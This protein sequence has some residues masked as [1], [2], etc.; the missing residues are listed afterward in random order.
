[1]SAETIGSGGEDGDAIRIG[2]YALGLLPA[3]E[4]AALAR[5][6][7]EEP[8]LAAELRFWQ[9]RLSDLDEEFA[10]VSPPAAVLPAIEKRLFGSAE[11]RGGLWESLGFWRGLAAAGVAVAVLSL[12]AHM[13]RPVPVDP[14]AFAVQLVAA[15]NAQEGSGVQ[16]VALFDA[17]TGNVRITSLSGEPVPDR[18]FELWYIEAG[19]DPVSMGVV[20]LDARTEIP[21][22]P[23]DR[24]RLTPGTV[25]AITLE[26]QGG[27]PTGDPTGPVVAAGPA[28]P[29]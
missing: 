28:T 26:P 13:L 25:L 1:M 12:G 9:S 2:E 3:Q 19:S 27:S 6:I 4:A 7:A 17:E 5:Q 29:I 20:P 22:G 11:A 15:L 23:A 16:F 24:A 18:D 10:E 14:D 21:L 8:A